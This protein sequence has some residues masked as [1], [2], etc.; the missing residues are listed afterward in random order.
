MEKL[1]LL[2]FLINF[3]N[4]CKQES[5]PDLVEKNYLLT[6]SDF[7]RTYKFFP[8]FIDDAEHE[9]YIQIKS[10]NNNGYIKVCSGYFLTAK[11]EN[12]FFDYAI[13]DF[14]NCQR[15]FDA[16]IN[17]YVEFNIYDSYKS[18]DIMSNNGYFYVTIYIDRL[19]GSDFSGTFMLFVTNNE[20]KVSLDELSK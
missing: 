14:V 17:N 8:K 13:N 15:M 5:I 4:F 10:L 6:K 2:I 12:I 9:I 20:I 1:L 11:D 3:P 19:T 16:N 7:F 18:S